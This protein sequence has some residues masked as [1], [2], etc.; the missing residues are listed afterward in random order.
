MWESKKI[1]F[2]KYYN[3]NILNGGFLSAL[4]LRFELFRFFS[5]HKLV[6]LFLFF[7]KNLENECE[8]AFVSFLSFL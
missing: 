7:K 8:P 6:S 3:Q 2:Y 1:L 5:S 4:T